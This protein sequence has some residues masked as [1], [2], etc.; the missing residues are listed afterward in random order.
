MEAGDRFADLIN[1]FLFGGRQVVRGED[2]APL[3]GRSMLHRF[4]KGRVKTVGGYR[5]VLRRV[6]C[7]SDVVIIGLENQSGVHYLMPLRSMEYDAAEYARQARDVARRLRKAARSGRGKA[8]GD[9]YISGFGREDRLT[10]VI[11]IVVYY[12]EEWDGGRCL[13]D[14]LDTSGMREEF[15]GLV[16]DYPLHLLNV[17]EIDTSVFTTDIRQVF[18]FVRCSGDR[19]KVNELIN[20]DGAYSSVDEEALEVMALYGNAAELMKLKKYRDDEGRIDMCKGIQDWLADERNE[21]RSEG[22]LEGQRQ[23][24][25]RINLLYVKLKDDDRIDDI[26]LAI[27]DSEYQEKLLEEYKL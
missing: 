6:V 27:N 5:D 12:G 3:D 4:V 25:A 10:P 19:H 9:E 13:R 24:R 2:V 26:M 16:N 14:L 11:T 7:G 8:S 21:G 22:L 1:G 18:D 23:E 15:L 20:G 17:R